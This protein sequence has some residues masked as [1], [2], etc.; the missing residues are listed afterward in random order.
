MA[1]DEESAILKDI[2]HRHQVK[3]MFAGH[4]HGYNETSI[5]DVKYIVTGGANDL[6]DPGNA[7]HFFRVHIEGETLRTEYVSFP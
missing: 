3:V 6:I 7:Q 4:Y 2:L 1:S 5:G